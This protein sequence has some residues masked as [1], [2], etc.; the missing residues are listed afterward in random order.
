MAIFTGLDN[1]LKETLNVDYN[2][3]TTDQEVKFL[4]KNN[5]YWGRFNGAI[6][7][8]SITAESGS[9]SNVSLYNAKLLT[10]DGREIDI[11]RYGQDLAELQTG[12]ENI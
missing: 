9:L 6:N 3:R 2:E 10:S 7:P 4:N 11:T 12:V 8:T 5:E 1:T